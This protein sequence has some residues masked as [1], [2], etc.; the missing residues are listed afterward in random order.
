MG[1][2]ELDERISAVLFERQVELCR[3]CAKTVLKVSESG[4]EP[5]P[6]Y[7]T[8]YDGLGLVVERMQQK[9]YGWRIAG[10]GTD[11]PTATFYRPFGASYT[12]IGK[13]VPE[14]VCRAALLALGAEVPA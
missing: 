12:E 8:T 6:A 9:G 13:T 3:V 11:E 2:R 5:V 10:G 4:H 1:S 7:S 14:A